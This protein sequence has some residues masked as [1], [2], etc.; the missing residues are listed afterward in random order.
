MSTTTGTQWLATELTRIR[1]TWP[2]G[3]DALD[4]SEEA[5]LR[6]LAEHA[7]AHGVVTVTDKALGAEL[8][9]TAKDVRRVCEWLAWRRVV[10]VRPVDSRDGRRVLRFAL[11][12]W[13]E[14]TREGA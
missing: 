14:P 2:E 6:W 4:D 9:Y 11:R 8:G 12:G 13:P 10:T 5:V 7:S 1:A 3:D